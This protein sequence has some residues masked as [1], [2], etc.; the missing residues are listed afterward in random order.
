MAFLTLTGLALGGVPAGAQDPPRTTGPVDYATALTA[1]LAGEWGDPALAAAVVAGLDPGLLTS[2]EA[3]VPLA[4]VASS[5]F[6]AYRPERRPAKAFDSV[7][8]Y[9]FGYHD[10]PD[11][12]RLPGPVNEAL[13][14]S[15][16]Q[17]LRKRRVPV[18]AQTEIAQI[19]V[20]DGVPGVT[21]ID[22]VV[23]PDG[24]PVYLSTAGVAAQAK[25][26]AAA[27]NDDLGT[28]AVVAFSDHAG[29]SVLTTEAA[30]LDAALARGVRLPQTY[31]PQSAQPWTRDRQSY[32]ATDLLGRI[33]TL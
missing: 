4:S 17:L 19:L 7:I 3:R 15:T 12:T 2:L 21:S 20:A 32:L 22:P 26:K 24:Q 1:R 25:E 8:V 29:R 10:G 5:P 11:G 31:D 28:V 9:A 13:A 16:G 33:A 23:G 6:L 27:A 18:Y 14:A 30:G